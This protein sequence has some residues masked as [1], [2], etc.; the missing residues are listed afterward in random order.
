MCEK[1]LQLL[2]IP[3]VAARIFR[4]YGKGD[5]CIINR[6]IRTALN[7]KNCI[8]SI[9]GEDNSFD[10]IVDEDAAEGLLRLSL[11]D[12]EGIVNLGSGVSSTV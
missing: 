3:F 9:C 5:R 8:L 1:E 7:Q 6:W 2:N 12:H 11:S 4:G 10:Y